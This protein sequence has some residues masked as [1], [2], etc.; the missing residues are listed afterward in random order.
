MRQLAL[1]VVAATAVMI[2][3]ACASSSSNTGSPTQRDMAVYIPGASLGAFTIT[4]DDGSIVANI[5]A[6]RDEVWRRIPSAFDSL[7][8]PISLID[9][10]SHVVGNEGVKLRAKLGNQ[11]LSTYIECGTTQVGPNADSYE[12][13]FTI[14][15]RLDSTGPATTRMT[16]SITAAAKPLAY[17]QAYSRCTSKVALEKRLLDIVAASVRK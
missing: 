4:S 8:I 3:A 5:G 1:P 16:T 17:S 2:A 11:R 14:M 13:Y 9:P 12:V 6:A 7:G 10:K 15:A